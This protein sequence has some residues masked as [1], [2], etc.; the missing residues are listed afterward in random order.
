MPKITDIPL[1]GPLTGAELMLVVQDDETALTT[2]GD[3]V[4]AVAQPFVDEVSGAADLAQEA[5]AGAVASIAGSPRL[6]QS[7]RRNNVRLAGVAGKVAYNTS[8]NFTSV[9]RGHLAGTDFASA[10]FIDGVRYA[11]NGFDTGVL[12][13]RALVFERA[14]D[15]ANLNAA[16]GAVGD[17]LVASGAC[18]RT[19]YQLARSC[20]PVDRYQSRAGFYY[21]A[22]LETYAADGVTRAAMAVQYTQGS[23]GPQWQE[24]FVKIG[25]A[26]WTNHNT[27]RYISVGLVT[28]AA[29]ENVAARF[30]TITAQNLHEQTARYRQMVIRNQDA[31]R[32]DCAFDPIGTGLVF[33]L[34]GDSLAM[35]TS[36]TPARTSTQV[37]AALSPGVTAVNI[38]VNGHTS[39]QI[40]A[41]LGTNNTANPT[42]AAATNISNASNNDENV[43]TYAT[44]RANVDA[45]IATF[46]GQ[47][48]FGTG[49]GEALWNT[50]K[51]RRLFQE[52]RAIHGARII[53]WD[54]YWRQNEANATDARMTGDGVHFNS[55]GTTVVGYDQ[56]RWFRAMNGGAPY[57]HEEVLPLRESDSAGT[58]ISTGLVLGTVTTSFRTAGDNSDDAIAIN[59]ATAAIT[60]GAGVITGGSREI[61]QKAVNF[62]GG[63]E[64]RKT[65]LMAQN[66]GDTMP[67]TDIEFLGAPV[68]LQC[69]YLVPV[70]AAN[71]TNFAVLANTTKISFVF[72]M[73]V[74]SGLSGGILGSAGLLTTNTAIQPRIIARN[75]SNT[76]IGGGQLWPIAPDPFA[77]NAYFGS[78]DTEAGI[79]TLSTN[80][81]SVSVAITADSIPVDLASFIYLFGSNG[82]PL[83]GCAMRRI[84]IF[85]GHA[86]NWT[87]AAKRA[88]FY[89]PLTNLPINTG[90]STVDGQT[91][92]IDIYGR[93][94]DWS[95]GINRGSLGN[96]L[97]VRFNGVERMGMRELS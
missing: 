46:T 81:D 75:T 15:A 39:A 89:D 58:V 5:A 68:L 18:T 64:N 56:T 90:G 71:T 12:F 79:A 31:L 26:G 66:A 96:L 24:G 30:D 83:R 40:L 72:F 35:Q 92:I 6:S 73:R 17:V 88:L 74:T 41:A 51:Q 69:P 78:I 61:I 42:Y 93:L 9:A 54:N 10:S 11:G 2:L 82:E 59:P 4:E 16:P 53:D 80:E 25:A 50:P 47:W 45:I 65:F 87:D 7:L 95:Q 29:T 57:V 49:S 62:R 19:Q 55:F 63:H 8:S 34:S 3:L 27:T 84:M 1:A 28:A 21:F 60:R 52:L 44:T 13:Y 48:L 76:V 38:G 14:P 36:G 77:L 70:D 22:V 32:N 20:V 94:F 97:P 33:R 23:D 67:R 43:A 86:F 85:R 91:A 37:V